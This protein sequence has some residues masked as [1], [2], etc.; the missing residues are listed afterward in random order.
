MTDSDIASVPGMEGAER[1]GHVT[2]VSGARVA[3]ILRNSDAIVRKPHA[4]A[5][6]VGALVKI[7]T[8]VSTMF[9]I[10]SGLNI[11]NPTWPPDRTEKQIMEIDL[12]GEA[13]DPPNGGEA[14]FE[15]GVS[16]LPALGA[17]VFATTLADLRR[18]YAR[19]MV[20]NV[21]IGTIHQDRSLPAFIL[22]DELLGKHFA[23]LGTT[24]SGK[25]CAVA[26]IPRSI[27]QQ[28]PHGHIVLL[29][30]HD[31]Y[32]HAFPGV[33]EKLDTSTLQLPYWLLNFAETVDA[34]VGRGEEERAAEIGILKDAILAAKKSFMGDVAAANYI[35]V[36]TPT[37]Y[38]IGELVQII[39]DAMGRLDKPE[40][41]GPFLRLVSKIDSLRADKRYS[42]MFSGLVVRDNMASVIGR[43][44]RV[45]VSSKPISIIDLSGV[46]S[47][48]VD[49]VVSMLT[50]IIFDFGVWSSRSGAA[51]VLL[52][53]EE[54]HRYVPSA[55][56]GAFQ[57]TKQQ[58]ARIAKEGRK[59]GVSLCLVS[60]RP[61]ELSG[62]I[63]S[64]CNTIF[65][66]RMNNERDQEFVANALP[67]SANGMLDSLPSLRNQEAIVVGEGVTVPM[68]VRFNDLPS[69]CCPQSASVA[70]SKAWEQDLEAEGFLKETVEHW[71][72]LSA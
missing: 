20:S 22:T 7:R 13:I 67:E 6:Q 34:I 50:R 28:H 57:P 1:L 17:G 43:I 60:Q 3:G 55:N 37:P 18:V 46:P 45:P 38:R 8:S 9:G 49:V 42:F 24:G 4:Q 23:V 2:S 53:C 33:A 63:L 27:L 69:D 56:A 44:I 58:I 14:M 47:E 65:A 16:V 59:Y 15:R 52:V 61:S 68:R 31:E 5:V 39:K 66:L 26:L 29:D 11:L 25:S 71:R 40:K 30:P 41:S 32:A 36:D 51:P 19:P 21:P 64:Q 70:F 35:T 12:F 62:T 10:V 48:I 54:A 72:R